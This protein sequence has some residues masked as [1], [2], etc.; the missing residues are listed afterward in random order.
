[1]NYFVKRGEQQFGPYSLA[2][3]QQ[4]VTQGN[5]STADLARS[6]GMTDWVPVSQIIGNVSVPRTFG[7]VGQ[8]QGTPANYVAPPRMHWAVVLLLSLVTLGLFFMVWVVLQAL[9]VR[10][11]APE[12]RVL[13]YVVAYIAISFL[14]G[15]V[16]G[17][18]G[19]S[20]AAVTALMQLV[21]FAL[22]LFAVF[23]M[24]THIE[25]YFQPVEPGFKLSGVVTFFFAIFY[26]QYH[27]RRLHEKTQNR[28]MAAAV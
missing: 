15:V 25:E 3:L 6:E 26:F 21:G 11:V 7:T 10:K 14:A 17:A 28:A 4:Y 22:Y 23:T 19:D 8:Q 13:H 5:I 1:M 2:A 20:A 16:D 27:F 9:W 18:V 24:R 12:T